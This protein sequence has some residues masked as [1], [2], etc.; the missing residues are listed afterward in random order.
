MVWQASANSLPVTTAATVMSLQRRAM[1]DASVLWNRFDYKPLTGE[2]VSK[3]MPSRG[4]Q[5]AKY[6]MTSIHTDEGNH[7][8]LV[9]RAI[10]KWVHGVEPALTIDHKDRNPKNNRIGNLRDVPYT[11]QVR[12]HGGCK[13][14]VEKVQVIKTRIAA[15]EMLK[16]IAADYSVSAIAIGDIKRGKTW[17]EVE[18]G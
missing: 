5:K 11:T 14:T 15:G 9:H 16:A 8:F 10:W 17:R 1:P 18:A 7:R 4:G 3:T 13:L 12:N 2:L 6:L